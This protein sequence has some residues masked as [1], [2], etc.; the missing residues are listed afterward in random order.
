MQQG[1]LGLAL[2]GMEFTLQRPLTALNTSGS[3]HS[4]APEHLIQYQEIYTPDALEYLCRP[5]YE[6][7]RITLL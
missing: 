7:S 1:L 2:T 4:G 6:C 3:N 5:P